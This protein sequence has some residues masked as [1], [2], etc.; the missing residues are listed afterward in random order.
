VLVQLKKLLDDAK[1][2]DER[3]INLNKNTLYTD[4]LKEE[5]ELRNSKINLLYE[6]LAKERI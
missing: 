4:E 6:R 5:N 1:L 2:I 3:F